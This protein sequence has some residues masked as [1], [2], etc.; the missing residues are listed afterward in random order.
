MRVL[1][2][3]ATGFLG[4][5]LV[6][7]LR[8]RGHT[9]RVLARASSDTRELEAQGLEVARASFHDAAGLRRAARGMEAIVHAAGGG[10][11]LSREEVFEANAGSMRALLDARDEESL[12]R[13][14]LVSSLAAHG[15]SRRGAPATE[16]DADAPASSYGES[17]R[18]AERIAAHSGVRAVSLRLPALYGPGE[19]RM[20]A[21][22]RSAKR[23]VVPL[24]HPEGQL[25]VLHGADA[26]AAIASAVTA[27][28]VQGPLYVADPTPIS[29]RALAQAIAQAMGRAD[30]RIVALPVSV[31]QLAAHGADAVARLRGR[32]FV[33]T[34]DKVRDLRA[35][36]QAC[37]PSLAMRTL[38]WR[39]ERDLIAGSL[40]ARHDYE[41]RGW[42]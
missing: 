17:K 15:P 14:V 26:A 1:V 32:A 21:L 35:E 37:D 12:T 10:M 4:E 27:P 2:T 3:G 33:L 18:E 42:L 13:V 28:D 39:P 36:N 9:L 41:R 20:V 29:R 11:A 24:V 16:R 40:E 19:H 23:G 25:S 22:Y 7:A 34:R 8:E 38:D 5:H 6:R 31:L 30:V